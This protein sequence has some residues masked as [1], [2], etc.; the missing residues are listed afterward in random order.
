[1]PGIV[2]AIITDGPSK[3]AW[4][5]PTASPAA[6][7]LIKE[8]NLNP[9]TIAATGK[10]GRVTKEDV[11]N[12]LSSPAVGNITTIAN[13]QV[14]RVK[15][16]RLR[17]TI[18]ERL[19][20][21]QNNA[22]TLTTFNEVD[23]T[24]IIKLRNQYKEKF[25]KKHGIKLGF[26]SFFLKASVAALKDIPNANAEIDGN[27]IIY[28]NYYDI[29]VAVS[30]DSGLIVPVVR[31]VDKLSF[32]DIEKTIADFGE[33][34]RANKIT[35]AELTGG[36]F[37]VTNGGVFGSLLSTPIINPPQ[38]AI[39]GMHKTMDRPVAIEGK[40]EIRPMMYIAL[41]YDHRIIDGKE[42]V[43]F[44]VRVKELVEN[45]DRLIFDL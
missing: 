30:T 6:S 16:S 35:M 1:M 17:Q 18:A 36:T 43:T 15:M 26:M 37:S 24:N 25:E 14:Q 44:L 21:S 33:R 34:A 2:L 38:S 39:L 3:T 22:A 11:L 41:S 5:R 13:R 4:A 10:D 7:K 40:I 32:S 9:S 19:K 28:K 8:N 23:M 45:P 12:R 29:S 31:D 27:E 42:A 20:A